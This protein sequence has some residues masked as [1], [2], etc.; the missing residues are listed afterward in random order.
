MLSFQNLASP[1]PARSSAYS[2]QGWKASWF[3]SRNRMPP[4]V[5]RR[6]RPSC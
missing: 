1:R 2:K 5:R 4:P 6:N 3:S